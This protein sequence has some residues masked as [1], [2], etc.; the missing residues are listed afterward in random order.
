MLD[1]S[2]REALT[3]LERFEGS[4]HLLHPN[5]TLQKL[6]SF[7]ESVAPTEPFALSVFKLEASLQWAGDWRDQS[8]TGYLHLDSAREKAKEF[9]DLLLEL[10]DVINPFDVEVSSNEKLTGWE[11]LH[12]PESPIS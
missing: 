3:N 10:S 7:I 11:Y 6:N 2:Q 4:I 1:Y 5:L 9:M 8:P 12:T